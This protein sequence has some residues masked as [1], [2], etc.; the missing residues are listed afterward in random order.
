M[1]WG[2]N[3]IL[4]YNIATRAGTGSHVIA[5]WFGE[6][7]G[8]TIFM[9]VLHSNKS[10]VRVDSKVI[11]LTERSLDLAKTSSRR[12][13]NESYYMVFNWK[14]LRK[15]KETVNKVEA[16]IDASV[17]INPRLSLIQLISDKL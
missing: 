14:K 11:L 13:L 17:T 5:E 12:H 3:N 15:E 4:L 1:C 7:V 9:Y 6:D 8:T 2:N 16:I 10:M